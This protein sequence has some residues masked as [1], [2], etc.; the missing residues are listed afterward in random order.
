MILPWSP[1]LEKSV[2][3]NLHLI[4]QRGK[5]SGFTLIEVM[6]A[7]VVTSLVMTLLM[8]ATYYVLQIR[9]KLNDEVRSGEL[10]ARQQLWFR[11]TVGS[12]LPAGDTS[13]NAFSGDEQKITALVSRPLQARSL[14]YPE[15]IAL[16]LKKTETQGVDLIYKSLEFSDA[17][18][19]KIMSWP[20]ST[21][22]F[23]FIDELGKEE[24][25]WN[26]LNQPLLKVPRA[27]SITVENMR[28]SSQKEVWF[29][30]IDADPW[31]FKPPPPPFEVPNNAN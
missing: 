1:N 28:D 25:A 24:K 17:P 20:D 2:N 7:L 15:S 22:R 6:V 12:I 23:A 3:S 27:I 4:S 13:P 30:R 5:Q 26:S 18:E 14:N 29:A 9:I 10:I 31:T 8:S 16:T 21:A 11:Q 19:I